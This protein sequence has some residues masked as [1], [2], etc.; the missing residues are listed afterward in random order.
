MGTIHQNAKKGLKKKNKTN[1]VFALK[2]N[3][4]QKGVVEKLRIDSPRK[5]NSAKR[6]VASVKLSNGRRVLAKIG[7]QG[8]EL[9]P[10]SHVLVQGGRMNDVPGVRYALI[11]GVYDFEYNTEEIKRVNRRSKYGIPKNNPFT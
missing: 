5:P 8:N 1:Y 4:Q 10:F 9:Q 2:K 7:G 6:D 11:R 3:P